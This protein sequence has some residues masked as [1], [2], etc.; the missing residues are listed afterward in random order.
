MIHTCPGGEARQA[1]W[2]DLLSPTPE[3]IE[4]VASSTGLRVPTEAE[5]SEIESTSRL[6]FEDGAY[7]LSTPLASPDAQGDYALIPAGFVLSSRYL[8]TIRYA[9]VAA[10]DAA[11]R[12]CESQPG[13]TAEAAFLGIL[14]VIVDR[15]ADALERAGAEC[16]HLSQEAFRRTAEE[17]RREDDL[18]ESLRRVGAIANRSSHIRDA[19]LGIGRIA[20]YLDESP[21]PA[22]PKLGAGRIKAIR[23]DVASL[24]EY[25]SSL[26]GKIQFLLDATLGLISV[27]QNEIVKTLTIASVVGIPPVVIAG[28]YGMNF[29]LMPELG[30]K[31]G[32]PFALFLMAVSAAIPYLWFKR[33]GWT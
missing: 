11:R 14:E 7:Y 8:L 12:A 21:H 3:E 2:I 33:R 23:A 1:V 18:R 24:T 30:W 9:H 29:H 27:E 25:E 16:E 31:Y 28:I 22:A 4:R 17:R 15:A 10:I 26:S 6:A 5:V 32:Y 19:L 20:A 13:V